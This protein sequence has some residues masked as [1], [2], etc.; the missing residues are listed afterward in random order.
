MGSNYPSQIHSN[1]YPTYPPPY[2]PTDNSSK[3][4]WFYIADFDNIELPTPLPDNG[5][6]IVSNMLWLR[7][8]WIPFPKIDQQVLEECYQK[9]QKEKSTLEESVA[10]VYANGRRKLWAVDVETL[11]MSPLYWNAAGIGPVPVRR[12]T[13]IAMNSLVK[14]SEG[15][16]PLPPKI[17]SQL[18]RTWNQHLDWI[19]EEDSRSKTPSPRGS[20]VSQIKSSI[21][22][23]I[24]E[25]GKRPTVEKLVPL[26]GL[27]EGFTLILRKG[28]PSV[29]TLD[30]PNDGNS[31]STSTADS[32]SNAGKDSSANPLVRLKAAASSKNN[33]TKNLRLVRV[34]PD[35][36]GHSEQSNV[37]FPPT[38]LGK[39]LDNLYTS[40]PRHL[41]LAVHGIGQT[42][43]GKL[44]YSLVKD[45]HD[46]RSIASRILAEQKTSGN[47]SKKDASDESQS[48]EILPILWRDAIAKDLGVFDQRLSQITLSS[49]PALRNVTSDASIDVLLYMTPHYFQEILRAVRAEVQRVWRLF[50]RHNPGAEHLTRVSFI[51]HSLGSAIV[52]DMLSIPVNQQEKYDG[53]FEFGMTNCF[54]A[55]GSPLPLF[56]ALKNIH[57]RGCLPNMPPTGGKD[58]NIEDT[59]SDVVL[60]CHQIYNIFFPNDPVAYR[61]EPLLGVPLERLAYLKHPVMLPHR[62]NDVTSLVNRISTMGGNIFASSSSPKITTA[63]DS[64]LM[65]KYP[66]KTTY[67]PDGLLRF[68][69]RG[70]VDF[71][72]QELTLENSYLSAISCHFAYWSD[73]DV[74]SFILKEINNY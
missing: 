9:R 72:V 60:N 18:M 54:F 44:G 10:A 2:L 48:F 21:N 57:Y 31:S 38:E 67:D 59:S 15:G 34:I 29:A 49:V 74:I 12:A 30:F 4:W 64:P 33:I 8:K 14:D 51:G 28:A 6:N 42:L 55:L 63:K 56:L 5:D 65:I 19:G 39:K 66:Q 22:N 53:H 3:S 50:C 45:L 37:L 11:Q 26:D 20:P 69:I 27:M 47:N 13:L 41:I 73:E 68:N 52:A 23:L 7:D 61:L 1:L 40:T 24:S 71:S 32:S 17:D 70:R 36:I 62:K 25:P 58:A 35:G 43:A 46:F 16:F